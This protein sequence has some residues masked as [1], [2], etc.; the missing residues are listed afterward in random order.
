MSP[1]TAIIAKHN[2]TRMLYQDT[3]IFVTDLFSTDTLVSQTTTVL[4][5][6]ITTTTHTKNN[7]NEHSNKGKKLLTGLSEAIV[8]PLDIR[9]IGTGFAA[10]YQLKSRPGFQ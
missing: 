7:N 9:L 4:S 6:I 3:S 2:I 10:R 8:K 5:T 1:V